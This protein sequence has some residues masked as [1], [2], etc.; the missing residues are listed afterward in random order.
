MIYLYGVLLFAAGYLAAF[1]TLWTIS[2]IEMD[3]TDAAMRRAGYLWVDGDWIH[4]TVRN[5]R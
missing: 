2:W 3:K 4:S 5:N 1:V